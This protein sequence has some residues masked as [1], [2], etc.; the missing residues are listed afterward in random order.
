MSVITADTIKKFILGKFEPV[1]Q[2]H[3]LS[4]DK[5]SD[6]FDL[7]AEGIVDSVGVLN[8]ITDVEKAFDVKLDMELMDAEQLTVLGPFCRYAAE[9]SQTGISKA[10]GSSM[11]GH[12][13]SSEEVQ[14]NLRTFIQKN[15]SI[16]LTDP[17]FTDDVHL[18]SAGYVDPMG[19][20]ILNNFIESNFAIQMTQSDLAAQPLNT[21]R[22]MATF[23]VR[24][25][26]R[27]I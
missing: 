25:R 3:G 2:N 18:Y 24:R 4:T 10:D 5:I 7:F 27:E 19:A 9:H 15:Y 12:P 26:K 8:L 13:L 22:Q 21:I 20:G 17:D 6:D 1:L 16:S 23:V 11:S 14:A